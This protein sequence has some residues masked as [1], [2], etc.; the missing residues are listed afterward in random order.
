MTL[1]ATTCDLATARPIGSIYCGTCSWTDCTL[2][3]SGGFYAADIRSPAARLR[4]YAQVF[5]IVEVDA[6]YYA[7]PS[8][9]NARLWVERTPPGFV[10]N[11]K[12]FGLLTQHPIDP[13]RLPD[14]M[15]ERLPKDVL[16]KGRLYHGG[17]PAEIRELVWRMH[18]EALR[19]LAEAGKLGCLLFQ[20]PHWFRKNRASVDYLREL[21]ERLPW[22]IAIEF[23]RRFGGA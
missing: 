8:E 16:E 17:V 3:E 18:I 5:P 2:I 21:R 4:Y 1:P 6:T 7:L 15:R 9:Q 10:F 23:Q 22:P 12:A 19:P 11:I 14:V 20:F 13:R